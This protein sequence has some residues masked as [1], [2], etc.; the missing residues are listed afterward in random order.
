[1]DLYLLFAKSEHKESNLWILPSLTYL[2]YVD[3][4]YIEIIIDIFVDFD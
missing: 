4:D 2:F 3:F 1:M